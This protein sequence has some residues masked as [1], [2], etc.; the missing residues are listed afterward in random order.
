MTRICHGTSWKDVVFYKKKCLNRRKVYFNLEKKSNA[1][2]V[3]ILSTTMT[4]IECSIDST[5]KKYGTLIV[6]VMTSLLIV[7]VIVVPIVLTKNRKQTTPIRVEKSVQST[8]TSEKWSSST[9]T[10]S[11]LPGNLCAL[12]NFSLETNLMT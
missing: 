6:A 10:E 1:A 11:K 5:K 12:T 3:E 4:L 8:K 2:T 9:T 7:T